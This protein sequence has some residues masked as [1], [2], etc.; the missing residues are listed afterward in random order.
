MNTIDVVYLASSYVQ[1]GQ[2]HKY[3]YAFLPGVHSADDAS[4][5]C[6]ENGGTLAILSAD[7]DIKD[8][9]G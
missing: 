8:V 1:I 3:C 2:S 9:A 6:S 5:I 4:K 7:D